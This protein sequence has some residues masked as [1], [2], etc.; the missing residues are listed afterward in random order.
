MLLEAPRA[1]SEWLAEL[2]CVRP[3]RGLCAT[4]LFASR[5]VPLGEGLVGW[6]LKIAISAAN[7]PERRL[8]SLG[9]RGLQL[10]GTCTGGGRCADVPDGF[11]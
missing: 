4:L 10:A 7:Q 1:Q 11:V 5:G 6:D 2:G 3:P 9:L 8:A